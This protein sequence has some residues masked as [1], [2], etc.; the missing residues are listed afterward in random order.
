MRIFSVII[1]V[2]ILFYS[3]EIY[4]QNK[5]GAKSKEIIKDN[6]ND[7]VVKDIDGKKVKLSDYNG[8]VL[9][10]VNTA[11][12]CGYKRQFKDLQELYTIY[13]DRGFEVLAF[14]S[15]DFNQEPLSNEEI[16][17]FCSSKY[18]VTYKLFDKIKVT[19]KDKSPLYERLTNNSVTE[20]SEIK[21]NFEK[22]I[23]S[24][25]GKIIARIPTNIGPMDDI[26]FI[27]IDNEL[28]R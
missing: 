23:I 28:A 1:S 21:W 22:F 8:K 15:N 18:N 10:I 12:G 4:A 5:S 3:F 6:V 16:K 14:P 9:L 27:L 25:S 24:K 19:G 11:S 7:I 2:V 20:K 17:E 13:K 26:P